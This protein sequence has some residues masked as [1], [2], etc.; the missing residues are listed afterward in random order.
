[1]RP[2]VEWNDPRLVVELEIQDHVTGGLQDLGV[3]VR[4]CAIVAEPRHAVGQAASSITE[5]LWAVGVMAKRSGDR[6]GIPLL[7]FRGEWWNLAVRRIHDQRRAALDS[8]LDN[9]V[10]AAGG[11]GVREVVRIGEHAQVERVSSSKIRR[12]ILKEPIGSCL[13]F[14]SEEHTSELQSHS[15]LVCRLL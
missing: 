14:R 13:E 6:G 11:V 8:S 9:P 10:R 5:S 1:M 3:T 4:A 12:G 15:D 2:P 7:A